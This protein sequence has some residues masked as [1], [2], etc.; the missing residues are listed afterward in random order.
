MAINK[1]EL[2]V[3]AINLKKR[4]C[5]YCLEPGHWSSHCYSQEKVGCPCG[6]EINLLICTKTQDCMDRKNWTETDNSVTATKSG[7][8]FVKKAGIIAPNGVP[9]GKSWLPVQDLYTNTGFKLKTMFDNC[10]QSTFLS[11]SAARRGNLRGIPVRYTLICTDGREEPKVGSLYNLVLKD[12]D[13][14]YIHI[15]AVGID[16]LSGQFSSVRISGIEK[17]FDL[18]VN[19]EDLDREGGDLDLL[20][21]TDLAELHPTPVQ[22]KD[23]LVLLKSRFGSGWTLYG[24]DNEVIESVGDALDR[25]KVNFVNTKDIQFLDLISSE[26]I[27]VDVPRKCNNCNACKE[28]KISSQRVSYLE[29]LEDKLIEDSIEYMPEK[30]RY[31]VSYPY[32]KEFYNLLPNAEVAMKRAFQLEQKLV[33]RPVDLKSANKILQDSFNRDVF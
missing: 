4:I 17:A 2:Y 16:K 7:A 26:S 14:K 6:S 10:S 27:G 22:V 20:V 25:S 18:D 13:G 9:M 31:K 5:T 21:G 28:C 29:S 3:K 19:D 23:K 33:K 12:K 1:A 11:N 24:Y 30:K 32:T 8:G 15:Q